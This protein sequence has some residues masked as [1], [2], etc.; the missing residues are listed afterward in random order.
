MKSL[1]RR[2]DIYVL[3][4]RQFVDRPLSKLA[5][6]RS[7]REYK[8]AV[9]IPDHSRKDLHRIRVQRAAVDVGPYTPLLKRLNRNP[10]R[11]DCGYCTRETISRAEVKQRPKAELSTAVHE[12]LRRPKRLQPFRPMDLHLRPFTVEVPSVQEWLEPEKDQSGKSKR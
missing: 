7:Q 12:E 5:E 4:D 6:V 9:E 3:G 2:L 1:L 11:L 10:Q 8:S